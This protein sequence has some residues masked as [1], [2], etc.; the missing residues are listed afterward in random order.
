LRFLLAILLLRHRERA[1]L[2][3]VPPES[4]RISRSGKKALVAEDGMG[5]IAALKLRR[6]RAQSNAISRIIPAMPIVGGQLGPAMQ[7]YQ[8][9]LTSQSPANAAPTST[10][11]KLYLVF[12][13]P[14]KPRAA[15]DAG[16]HCLI[17]GRN[18]TTSSVP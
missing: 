16:G 17:P 7:N 8:Q 11:V 12:G 10:S 2:S 9:A 18:P 1:T 13:E 4:T 14:A 5:Q 15:C 6:R 3:L